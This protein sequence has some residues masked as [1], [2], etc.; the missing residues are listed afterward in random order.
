MFFFVFKRIKNDDGQEGM[1]RTKKIQQLQQEEDDAMLRM[2]Q[3]VDLKSLNLLA[4]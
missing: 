3:F 1:R 4:F 2:N